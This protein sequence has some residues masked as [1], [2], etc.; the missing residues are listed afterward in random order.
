MYDREVFLSG[1]AF[2][3]V[4]KDLVKP[5]SVY[6]NEVITNVHGTSFRVIAYDEQDEV[7]V[8]VKSGKVKVRKSEIKRDEDLN[9]ITLLPNQAAS[10]NKNDDTFKNISE[11]DIKATEEL[12]SIDNQSFDFVN[13][14]VKEV[15]STLQDIYNLRMI[16]PEQALEG[17]YITTSLSDVPLPEKLKI[18]C[19]S[20]GNDTAYELVGDKIIISSKGCE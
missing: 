9:E 18:I 5:F 3:E 11:I 13:V 12:E 4:S 7:K 1:E 17:C 2:F 8:L 6:S 15:F 14:P 19:F 20:I 16:Y 10:Y